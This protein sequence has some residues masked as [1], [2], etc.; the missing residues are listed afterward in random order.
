MLTSVKGTARGVIDR[1]NPSFSKNL[2]SFLTE[3]T[4]RE[5]ISN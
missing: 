5:R 3:E 1:A 4:Y 2:T